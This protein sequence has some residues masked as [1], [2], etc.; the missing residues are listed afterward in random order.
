MPT[1]GGVG[2]L[3]HPVGPEPPAVYWRRRVVLLLLVLGL[4]ALAVT[5][6]GGGGRADAPAAQ[7]QDAQEQSSPDPAPRPEPAPATSAPDEAAHEE[8]E[9]CAQE[10]LSVSVA[11]DSSGYGPQAAPRFTVTAGNAGDAACAV[12]LGSVVLLVTS[13]EDRVWSSE[14]CQDG[15]EE[16]RVVLEPGAEEQQTVTWQRV[17]SA[18]GCPETDEELAPGTY[19]VRASVGE[20]ASRATQFTLD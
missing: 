8:A 12:D 18:E 2:N 17:R 5:L 9:P 15:G 1:V 3:L 7:E 16:R 20:F 10:Q 4:V 6:T 13:G 19:Q 14:D 11:T